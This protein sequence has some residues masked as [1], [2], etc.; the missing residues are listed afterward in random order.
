[1]LLLEWKCKEL[2]C[3]IIST[4]KK[5]TKKINKTILKT[6]HGNTMFLSKCAK[7]NSQKL[8]FNKDQE[9]S[10]ILRN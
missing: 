10:E 4:L 3:H 7:C 6:S 2:C 1:M 9:A 8:R 5:H